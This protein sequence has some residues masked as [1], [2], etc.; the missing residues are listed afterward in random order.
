MDWTSLPRET[1]R[2]ALCGSDDHEI[3]S[4]RRSWPV[5]R[6]NVCGLAYL[7]ER[8][9]ESSLADVYG[10]AYYE[11]GDVGY[12]GY[13]ET[14]RRFEGLFRRI[15]D[16]RCRDLERHVAGRR[17]LE[18]GC[19][20][21]LLLDHLRSRGWRVSGVEVSPLSASYARDRLSLDVR[22][23]SLESAGYPPGSFDAV[24]ML[25][26]LEHLHRPFDALGEVARLLAPGGT[27]V[28]QCPWELS[29]WEEVLQAVMRGM[30]TGTI[31]PDAVPAHLYF[32]SPRT[33][34]AF[35]EKGGFD[36]TGRQS[37]NYGEIRR[38]VS[39]PAVRE[40]SAAETV[41]RFAY[42]RLGVRAALYRAARAAGL[43]NGLIRYARPS[44][45]RR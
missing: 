2:C 34:D 31:E 37:G 23:G 42:F 1:V 45:A 33:L 15:F 14:F 40:G 12:K 41:F 16:R 39:P 9:V 35:L 19:A 38:R 18:V 21:G 28:V 27:L 32:F 29:H 11:D 24:L 36:I 44:G 6:C 22:T 20:Y 10:A 25:D 7:R 13:M 17:L 5:A 30:R 4:F 26:V 43:G 8:P 3:L